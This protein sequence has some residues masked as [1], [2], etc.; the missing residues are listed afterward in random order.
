MRGADGWDRNFEITRGVSSVTTS[1]AVMSL[2]SIVRL[3]QILPAGNVP[4]GCGRWRLPCAERRVETQASSL[5]VRET[6]TD[7]G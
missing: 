4:S 3:R 1:S 7:A 5:L 2:A 6:P